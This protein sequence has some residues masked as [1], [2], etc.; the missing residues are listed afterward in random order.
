MIKLS[1]WNSTDQLCNP[2]KILNHTCESDIECLTTLICSNNFC[3]CSNIT[4]ELTIII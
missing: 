1:Y 2:Q 4:Y 3:E